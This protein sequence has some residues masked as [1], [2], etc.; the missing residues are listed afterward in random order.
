[1]ISMQRLF[2]YICYLNQNHQFLVGQVNLGVLETLVHQGH[3]EYR[4]NPDH[5]V[6]L[7][8]IRVELVNTEML[9]FIIY[10]GFCEALP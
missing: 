7:Q 2:L 1:M 5:L 6:D 9:F 4:Y 3:Q 10:N 8:P